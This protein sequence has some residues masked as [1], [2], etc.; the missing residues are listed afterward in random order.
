MENIMIFKD[1]NLK[2]CNLLVENHYSHIAMH[3]LMFARITIL[4]QVT[5]NK[6]THFA[7]AIIN[8]TVVNFSNSL[9]FKG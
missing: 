4:I 3:K 8:L 6:K 9:K 2:K 1:C 7:I 5:L